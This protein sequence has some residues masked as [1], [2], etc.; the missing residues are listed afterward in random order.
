M[1]EMNFKARSDMISV[2][3]YERIEYY[4]TDEVPMDDL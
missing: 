4:G 2:E 3:I 1:K